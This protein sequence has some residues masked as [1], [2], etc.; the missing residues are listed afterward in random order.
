MFKD[1]LPT[2]KRESGLFVIDLND[3]PL[4]INFIVKE[5]SIVSIPPLEK[6]GN[7]MHPRIEVLV[8]LNEGLSFIWQDE[9]GNICEEAMKKKGKFR[10]F[11]VP[12]H[13]PHAV[14]NRSHTQTG[15]L[16]EFADAKQT[17]V[18]LIQLI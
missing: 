3:I 12:S 15:I 4:P 1:F 17:D 5:K 8:G 9:K 14:V 13:L 7:H 18:E 2:Y 16:V 6:G 11:T 10:V